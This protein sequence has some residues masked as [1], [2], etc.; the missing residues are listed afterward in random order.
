MKNFGTQDLIKIAILSSIGIAIKPLITPLIKTIS[1]PLMIPGGSLAGGFYMMWMVLAMVIVQK[2]GTAILFGIVQALS[3]FVLGWFGSHGAFTLVTYTL[4][5]VVAE[6]L[7]FLLTGKWT[8][9]SQMLLVAGANLTGSL[10][11]GMIF[12]RMPRQALMLS[13]LG[14]ILSG[15]L[16]GALSYAIYKRLKNL[17]IIG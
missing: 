15:A 1:A 9:V 2:P 16:G 8:M 12:F 13:S 14:A 17:R 6:G 5:G 7:A 10:L 11:M 3:V 4:P